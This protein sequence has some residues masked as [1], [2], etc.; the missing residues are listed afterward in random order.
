MKYTYLLLVSLLLVTTANGKQISSEQC[1]EIWAKGE[2]IHD[3][4]E[5]E[6]SGGNYRPRS[7]IRYKGKMYYGIMTLESSKGDDV[8]IWV[9]MN[10]WDSHRLN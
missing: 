9:S 10:C 1:E 8:T 4:D 5:L 2:I 7:Y 6:V 3:F